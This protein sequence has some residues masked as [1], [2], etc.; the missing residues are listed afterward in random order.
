VEINFS[1]GNC[2]SHLRHAFEVEN[3][4]KHLMDVVQTKPFPKWSYVE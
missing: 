2:M 1:K 4:E 3:D